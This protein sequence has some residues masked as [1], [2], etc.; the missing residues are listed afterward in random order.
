M[1]FSKY[2]SCAQISV[3]YKVI[4]CIKGH[5]FPIEGFFKTLAD[6]EI[7]SSKVHVSDGFS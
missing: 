7:N 2:L 4:D 6:L 5:K 3:N 1:I